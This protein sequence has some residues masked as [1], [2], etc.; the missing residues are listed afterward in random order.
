MMQGDA[1]GI[2]IQIQNQNGEY[3]T[4]ADVEDVEVVIGALTKSLAAGEI[5]YNETG[6][7]F[8]FNVTQQ[9]TFAFSSKQQ[10]TQVR[11]KLS[12]GEVFGCDTTDIDVIKSISKEVL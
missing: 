8:V 6:Q 5:T 11:V 4:L 2:P 10:A 9:E 7:C 3:L 12:T 1:Y